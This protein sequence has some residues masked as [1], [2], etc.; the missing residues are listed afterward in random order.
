MLKGNNAYSSRQKRLKA[1]KTTIF[2]L[3]EETRSLQQRLYIINLIGFEIN[4]H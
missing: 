1:F 2:F 4:Y 3:F